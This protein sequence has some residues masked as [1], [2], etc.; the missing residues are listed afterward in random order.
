M[1][2][3]LHFS[4]C[5]LQIFLGAGYNDGPPGMQNNWQ[6]H[7]YNNFSVP[8]VPGEEGEPP[9]QVFILKIFKSLRKLTRD[10]MLLD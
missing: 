7:N 1:F 4:D 5:S 8:Q 2:L 9:Q 10:C 3:S 6:M